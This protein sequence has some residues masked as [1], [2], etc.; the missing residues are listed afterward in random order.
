MNR[1]CV[2]A[3]KQTQCFGIKW[4]EFRGENA[5]QLV[6]RPCRIQKRPE[7]VEDGSDS[8]RGKCLAHR[9]N[10]LESRMIIRGKEES[11]A[12]S[13]DA[14]PELFRGKVDSNSERFKHI[15]SPALGG[16]PAVTVLDHH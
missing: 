6:G 9:G 5:H 14:L 7:Q 4:Q 13:L 1:P 10:R 15:G 16:D 3:T 11:K 2:T 12:A 8:L